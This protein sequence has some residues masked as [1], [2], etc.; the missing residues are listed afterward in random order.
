MVPDKY[1]IPWDLALKADNKAYTRFMLSIFTQACLCEHP[2]GLHDNAVMKNINY[3]TD[4]IAFGGCRLR[5]CKCPM[6]KRDNLK[7]LE[8]KVAVNDNL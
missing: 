3:M 1:D 4:S 6:Y 2:A 8:D 7:W 5:G